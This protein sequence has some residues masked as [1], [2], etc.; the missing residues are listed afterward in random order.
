MTTFSTIW[1]T[2]VKKLAEAC[3][4]VPEL[5]RLMGQSDDYEPSKEEKEYLESISKK[6]KDPYGMFYISE[7]IWRVEHA[8]ADNR[9]AIAVLAV[10]KVYRKLSSPNYFQDV[11]LSD[12]N[13][14]EWK[15]RVALRDGLHKLMDAIS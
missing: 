12:E 14:E 1:D 8:L 2:E 5:V 11:F 4:T 7:M 3:V 15:T 10:S 13:N 6:Y 9:T